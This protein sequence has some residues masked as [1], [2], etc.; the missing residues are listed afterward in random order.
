MINKT[1][2]FP[3]K[4]HPPH[5]GHAKTILTLIPKYEK[6]II[7][8]SGDVPSDKVT[9]VDN[10]FNILKDLF[11]PFAN[12]ELVKI[13]GVLVEKPDLSGLPWFDVLASGNPLVLDWAERM[14]LEGLFVER[15]EGYL[16]SGTEIRDELRS[17]K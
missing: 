17:G 12:V 1:V 16:F 11:S 6:V 5:L 9:D 7:G 8:V 13:T 4:F 2:F 14:G 3:G 15:A 10:I